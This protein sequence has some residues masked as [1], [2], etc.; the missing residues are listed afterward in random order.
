[1]ERNYRGYPQ[2]MDGSNWWRPNMGMAPY[3]IYN[4]EA[5]Q[6]RPDKWDEKR[7]MQ[8]EYDYIRGLYPTDVRRWQRFVEEEFDRNDGP[9]SS[10]YDEYPDREW[11]YRVR[12]R[13]MKHAGEQGPVTNEDMVLILMLH[14]ML[15]RRAKSE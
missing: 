14:E 6:T 3:M 4:R 8:A 9:G 12:K 5:Q 15:R 2:G 10:I 11:I 1:M 13:I 7:R